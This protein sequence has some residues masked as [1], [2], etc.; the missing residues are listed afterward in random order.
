MERSRLVVAVGSVGLLFGLLISV[1][2]VPGSN[3]SN[4]QEI[5]NTIQQNQSFNG[6]IACYPPGSIEVDLSERVEN[7]TELECVCRKIEDGNIQ[8]LPIAKSR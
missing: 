8:I 5:E 3:V 2:L 7:A 1:L 6:S 4:C